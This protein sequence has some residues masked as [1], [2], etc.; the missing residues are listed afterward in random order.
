MAIITQLFHYFISFIGKNRKNFGFWFE[1]NITY[2]VLKPWNKIHDLVLPNIFFLA[3]I[4]E[5]L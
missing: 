1:G 4:L 5:R 2:V 3:K